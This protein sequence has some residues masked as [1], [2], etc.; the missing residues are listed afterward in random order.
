MVRAYVE[1]ARAGGMLTTAKHFPGHGD[2]SSD[3]H[4]ERPVV[5]VDR[6]R[7]DTVELV[8]FRTAVEAGVDSIMTAHVALPSIDPSGSSGNPVAA[9]F[10]RPAAE[11]SSVSMV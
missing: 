4:Y 5:G 8:P 1:G 11:T 7:L 2:T 9:Y 6:E 10:S 3:S